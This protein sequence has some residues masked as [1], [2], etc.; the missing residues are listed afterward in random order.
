MW[1]H[2]GVSSRQLIAR[3]GIMNYPPSCD[4]DFMMGVQ[5][6][7]DM[8]ALRNVGMK[9]RWLEGWPTGLCVVVR[10]ELKAQHL[11]QQ[12]E[13]QQSKLVRPYPSS[14]SDSP[15]HFVRPQRA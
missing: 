1:R 4:L 2:G 3:P 12:L 13:C 9:A 7:Y 11:G 15:T 8:E 10:Y 14:V 6:I 5:V